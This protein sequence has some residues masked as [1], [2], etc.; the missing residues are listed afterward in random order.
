MG[1]SKF[2]FLNISIPDLYVIATIIVKAWVI[3]LNYT[4]Y[5]TPNHLSKLGLLS[6]KTATR[7]NSLNKPQ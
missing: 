7:I 1:N 3:V 6:D 5:Y 4:N 2:C